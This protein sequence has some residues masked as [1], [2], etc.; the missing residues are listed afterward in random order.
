MG[1]ASVASSAPAAPG[2]EL[3]EVLREAE[4]YRPPE[5]PPPASP[6]SAAVDP[7]QE[8][9]H[10]VSD[11]IEAGQGTPASEQADLLKSLTAEDV[12]DFLELA[13]GLVAY[14][15]GDHWKLHPEE[16]KRI[17]AWV[18]KAIERHGIEWVARWLPDIMAG[19]LLGYAIL[20]RV[21]RDR[22]IAAEK[23]LQAANKPADR[24]DGPSGAT[25]PT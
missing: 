11:M 19:A 13:F 9:V 17:G 7:E 2:T 22:A 18:R 24:K 21:D 15:R 12:A 1:A 10:R 14:R 16:S 5:P 8:V 4:A 23:K 3:A 20:K 6:G 25:N